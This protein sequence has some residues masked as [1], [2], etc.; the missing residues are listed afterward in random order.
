MCSQRI[1]ADAGLR[2]LPVRCTGATVADPGQVSVRGQHNSVLRG[3]AAI[4]EL[5]DQEV[6]P[7]DAAC[8]RFAAIG[9]A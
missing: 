5:L 3:A 1:V 8:V 6:A 9:I 2:G 7:R 4:E